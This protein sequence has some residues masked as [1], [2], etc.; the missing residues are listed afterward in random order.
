VNN[1]PDRSALFDFDGHAILSFRLHGWSMDTVV[2]GTC[3]R[4][5]VPGR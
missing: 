3:C 5:Q 2:I 1:S 4:A